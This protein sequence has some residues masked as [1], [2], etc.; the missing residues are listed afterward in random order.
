MTPP[1]FFFQEVVDKKSLVSLVDFDEPAGIKAGR[2]FS[3]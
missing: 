2:W 3:A 1:K